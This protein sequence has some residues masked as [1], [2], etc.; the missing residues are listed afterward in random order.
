MPQLLQPF[1]VNV[2][3]NFNVPAADVFA[4]LAD[5][6][7]LKRV[8]GI[9]VKRIK[10]G[11]KDPNGVGSVRR[12]GPPPFGI[13][14]TVTAVEANKR[15]DYIITKFGGP[16]MNHNGSQTFSEKGSGSELHW[17]INFSSLPGL[18]N[19]VAKGLETALKRGLKNL[20]YQL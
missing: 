8:F 15:I 9:P 2:S 16:V 10:D 12:L 7:Q 3:Q 4:I 17:Q 14:E 20:S 11:D 1:T 19:A 18:G 5:H 6:N 13:Q